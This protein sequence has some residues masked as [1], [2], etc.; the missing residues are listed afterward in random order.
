MKSIYCMCIHKLTF[1]TLLLDSHFLL[2]GRNL[3]FTSAFNMSGISIKDSNLTY[4][5][6]R[7]DTIVEHHHGKEVK[8]AYRWLENPDA[9]E[10]H[11]FVDSQNSITRPYLENCE[12]WKKI[13]EKLKNLWNYQKFGC[14]NR[15][16][17]Y[18]Y[19]FSNTGLQNQSVLYQLKSLDGESKVFLDPNTLS[20]DGTVALTTKSFSENGSYMAYGLSENGSDWN[21][22]RIRCVETAKDYDEVLERVKFS[23]VSWTKDNKGFFYAQYPHQG[24]NI[25]GSETKQ[26]KNQKL[27][28]HRIGECQD[29]DTLVVE[30]PQEPAWRI[31]PE[32]SDCGKYLIL[33]IQVTV[34]DNLIYYAD[35]DLETDITSKL[36]IKP[37]VREFDADYYYVTNVGSK[38]YFCTNKN[39][40]NY[41][42]IAIDFDAPAESNWSTVI[43][44]NE[45]DV[46]D[47]VKCVHDDK[48]MVCYIRDV[49]SILQAH[50]LKTGK[51]IKQFDLDIGT[52]VEFSGKKTLSEIFYQ[53]SSFLSPGLIYQY[54]FQKPDVPPSVI[55][56]IDFKL[57]GF[58]RSDYAV[59]QIF[60]KS[61]D[62]TKIPMY[63]ICKKREHREPRPC[64]LYGYG[65]FNYSILPSFGI[66]GL[67][68]ID[69][70][71]GVLAYPNIRGGGEY[72]IKWHNGGRLLNKQ[73]VF[74]DFQSA[75]A[76]LID[77]NYTTK[78]RLAI[79]GGSNGGLLVGACINQRPELF[80]AA[81]AQVGVMDMLRFCK[82]TIG[83]AW[84]SDYGNPS[85]KEHFENLL[86][87]SPLHNI[88]VP[89]NDKMEYPSTLILTADHDDR[90]SPL[91]SLKFAAA[92]QEAVRNSRFQKNP[93]LL[94][95]YTNAGHGAGKP[96]AMRIQEA[97]DILTF[98][99]KSLNIDT[100]NLQK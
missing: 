40:P 99:F 47:W 22:I 64:L 60:Y 76:Y 33:L 56:E 100:V 57:D 98:F 83:H 86:K 26:N 39:A 36:E 70:F 88:H 1:R 49:K 51:L 80:G 94:R 53:F 11:K 59:E 25:D 66:T 37:I 44:E 50:E 84:I 42:L 21:K 73:N 2:Q 19:Y 61:K 34:R 77:K 74:D 15:H 67:M 14:Y 12:E 92:L 38:F 6:A 23:K 90:V 68:F 4:P 82:F 95:V 5:K 97:T 31:S 85:E 63:I 29:K 30:F 71:D 32:V 18:Y 89:E 24:G 52:I 43:P 46:M 69:T 48:L 58:Q 9:D 3:S 8:D 62:S 35:L 93:I 27:Y 16:G 79:Q 7:I 81:V 72:G 54:D 41:R 91:H 10:T 65:G 55:L 87:Y 13:H 75:A 78:D 96:T 45:R 28:Y 20:D 17:K